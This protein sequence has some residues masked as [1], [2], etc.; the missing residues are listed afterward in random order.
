VNLLGLDTKGV[1]TFGGNLY[2]ATEDKVYSHNSIGGYATDFAVTEN[3]KTFT[4]TINSITKGLNYQ[5][6]SAPGDCLFLSTSTGITEWNRGGDVNDFNETFSDGLGEL[7]VLKTLAYVDNTVNIALY[8]QRNGGL[9]GVYEDGTSLDWVDIDFSEYIK[10][11]LVLDFA[12]TDNLSPN[13]VYFATALGAL[14]LPMS[15]ISDYASGD[16]NL[17]S[18]AEFFVIE[19]DGGQVPIISLAYDSSANRLYMGTDEGLYSAAVGTTQVL[20]EIP[21]ILSGTENNRIPQ[22]LLNNTYRVYAS[23]TYLF[24]QRKFDSVVVILPFVAGL[25]GDI[26][27]MA[28]EGNVL[29]ISGTLGLVAL[30]VDTVF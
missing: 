11:E 20:N 13:Y 27:A 29:L 24:L 25:P 2:T 16:V 17:L 5:S 6:P 22:I 12:V 23:H 19:K 26:K 18:T 7:N 4:Y 15:L 14:R 10:G 30:D 9:G 28:W 21:V 8:F 1:V 3:T